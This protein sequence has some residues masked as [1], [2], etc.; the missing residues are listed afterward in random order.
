MGVA[1]ARGEEQR[2]DRDENNIVHGETLPQ[3]FSS[4]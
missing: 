1:F 4:A 2:D 3:D